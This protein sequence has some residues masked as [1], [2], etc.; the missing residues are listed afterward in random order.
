MKIVVKNIEMI[1]EF[2]NYRDEYNIGQVKIRPRRFRVLL[3][4]DNERKV[5][6]IDRILNI[7]EEGT[8]NDSRIVFHCKSL[9]NNLMTQYIIKYQK[10]NTKWILFK[11]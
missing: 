2:Y 10:N 8:K 6:N 5:I 4:D 7:E 1:A 11:M 3:D 9:L